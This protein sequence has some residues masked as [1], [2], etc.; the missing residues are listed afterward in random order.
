[1]GVKAVFGPGTPTTQVVDG[2]RAAAA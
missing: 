1:L 2:I